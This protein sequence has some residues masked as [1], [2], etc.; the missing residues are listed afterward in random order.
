MDDRE[1]SQRLDTIQQG[2]EYTLTEIQELKKNKI[3]KEKEEEEDT[4]TIRKLKEQG[5]I[6]EKPPKPRMK[7]KE[8]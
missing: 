2:I 6:I 5:N 7:E 3:T 1:L 4:P 8:D